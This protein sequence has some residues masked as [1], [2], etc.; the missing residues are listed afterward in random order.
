MMWSA[1]ILLAAALGVESYTVHD[2]HERLAHGRQLKIYLPKSAEKLEFIPAD[3]PSQVMV[4]WEKGFH[5]GHRGRVSGTGSDRRWYIDKVTYEDQGTYTQKDFWNKEISTVKVAVIPRH[6]YVKCVAGESLH[7]SLE[8]I[9]VADSFL[10]FSG[11]AGN[12]TLVQHGTWVP[13]SFP[14][15]LDRIEI[16]ST[17]ISIKNVNYT[18]EGRYTL[19]DRRD[20]VVSIT[21]MDLTDHHESQGNPLIALLLLLGI[22]AGICCCCRKKI[23]KK[24]ANTAATLQTTPQAVHPPPGGP[25]GPAPPYSTPGQPGAVYY[26]GPDP[27]M[28]P[29]F[30]PPPMTG[31]GQWNGPP[32]S[33]GYNPAYPPQNPGYPPVGPAM[34]PPTLPS[35]WNGPPPGQYPPGPGAPM[36]YAPGPVMYSSPPPAAASEPGK[37]E[38]KM[39]NMYPSPAD[40]LLTATPQAEAAYSPVAPVAP[41]A[42]SSDDAYKFQVDKSTTNFL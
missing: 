37:E 36:G 3:Y 23:F 34:N 5:R 9:D 29:S 20:R 32:P 26:H 25:V 16:H 18:D 1:V 40:P 11:E 28:G 8:G 15:Y 6:N 30:H 13:H 2:L 4:Y 14:D 42:P 33:P 7:I 39:E 19:K 31:P 12:F 38:L 21:R 41:V 17:T 24:K 22:P 27:S 35:Q 10:S